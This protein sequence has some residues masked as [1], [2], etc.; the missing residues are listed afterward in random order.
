MNMKILIILICTFLLDRIVYC[1]LSESD[2]EAPLFSSEPL[3]FYQDFKVVLMYF[4][5]PFLAGAKVG[6][7]SLEGESTVTIVKKLT[8]AFDMC[9]ERNLIADSTLMEKFKLQLLAGTRAY[10]S[11]VNYSNLSTPNFD[12]LKMQSIAIQND[13]LK[14]V[15]DFGGIIIPSGWVGHAIAL[16]IKPSEGSS[17]L[18]D[19][20]VVNTGSGIEYHQHLFDSESIYPALSRIWMQFKRIP[21]EEFLSDENPWFIYGLILLQ[22]QN[23]VAS[24]KKIGI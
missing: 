9:M 15:G 14:S 21:R 8:E 5:E 20:T 19:L 1:S 3:P 18:F 12:F 6:G 24:V 17:G 23:F 4:S 16:I 13:I 2:T 7:Q 11:I 22:Q 10:K